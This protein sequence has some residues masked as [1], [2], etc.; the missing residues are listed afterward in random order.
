L[1]DAIKLEIEASSLVHEME[2]I[3]A[4][5]SARPN[6][7]RASVGEPDVATVGAGH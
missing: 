5:P 4:A 1:G 6:S 3:V 2:A 7:E